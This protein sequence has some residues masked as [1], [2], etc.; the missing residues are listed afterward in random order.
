MT[1]PNLDNEQLSQLRWKCRRGML[2]LDKVLNHYVDQ[3]YSK[4]SPEEQAAF[5][6]CLNAPD[7]TLWAWL[8]GDE[9]P[10]N[11]AL[12]TCVKH[13]QKYSMEGND[14]VQGTGS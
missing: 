6:E 8:I 3:V 2:E 13:I 4:L 14:Y 9:T 5:A 7:P 11:E 10:E 12:L 1:N